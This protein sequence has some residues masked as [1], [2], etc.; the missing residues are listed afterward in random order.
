MMWDEKKQNWV[1]GKVK[2]RLKC[3][4]YTSFH[5]EVNINQ[6]N[7]RNAM[8]RGVYEMYGMDCLTLANW[9]SGVGLARSMSLLNMKQFP[10]FL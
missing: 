1:I 6:G 2:A 7:G 10:T 9:P 8:C 3:S 4:K 5:C